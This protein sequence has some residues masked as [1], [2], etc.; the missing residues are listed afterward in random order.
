MTRDSR[1]GILDIFKPTGERSDFASV[2]GITDLAENVLNA[3][4]EEWSGRFEDLAR[5]KVQELLVDILKVSKSGVTSSVRKM[6]EGV[7]ISV[8]EQTQQMKEVFRASVNENVALIKSIPEQY[9]NRLRGDVMRTITTENSSLGELT[10]NIQ[11]Y[12]GMTYRRASNIAMDQT[13]KAYQSFN[14]QMLGQAGIKK[15]IWIHTGGTEHP[16][17]KHKAFHKKEFDLS[18]GAPIGDEGGN[19]VFPGQCVNC[20]CTFIPIIEF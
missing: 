19:Y 16:R 8:S 7:T 12:G 3:L 20:R 15:G 11:K 4:Y 10:A 6:A 9:F 17:P 13:R 1:Q 18:K 5:Q 2:L 14:Q